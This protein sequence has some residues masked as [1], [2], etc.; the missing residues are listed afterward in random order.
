MMRI[1]TIT[2][3]DLPEIDGVQRL[4][5][6][7][8]MHEDMELFGRILDQDHSIGYALYSDDQI[9]GY[10]LGYSTDKSRTD[11]QAGPE[12]CADPD[13]M[14][15]HDLCVHPDFQ[16]RGVGGQL[17]A[18]FKRQAKDSVYAGMIAMAIEGRLSHWEGLGFE[19][20]A[21]SD[22]HGTRSTRVEAY[23]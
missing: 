6:P 23:F 11:F 5:F 13:M 21:K 18:A 19:A 15:L 14:Y 1:R 12:V 20:I 16:G 2:Q 9:S 22:Y 8:S 10:I 4:G 3:Q 7:E 17:F